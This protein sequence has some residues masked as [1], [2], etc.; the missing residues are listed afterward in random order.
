MLSHIN[1]SPRRGLKLNNAE[2]RIVPICEDV[3]L[4]CILRQ[5]ANMQ[6]C[7]KQLT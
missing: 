5:Y 3:N 1:A 2:V 6:I 7:N 4:I